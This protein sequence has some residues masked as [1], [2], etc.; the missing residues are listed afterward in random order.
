MLALVASMMPVQVWAYFNRGSVSVALGTTAVEVQA[1]A[2]A[3]VTVAITPSS[4][5][6]TEGCGMPKCPQGCSESCT[7]ENGQCRCAGADYQTYYPSATASSSNASVA[8]ATYSG[9]ALTVYGKQEGEATITVRASLRQFTDAEA[10]LSVKVS[11]AAAGASSGSGAFVDVPEVADTTQED[12]ANV[13]DKVA[14]GRPIHQVRINDACNT[15]VEL[16]TVAGVDGE[17]T[18]WSGDT[19]YHPAYSLTFQGLSY[20]VG[21]LFA[22]DPSLEVLTE[23]SGTLNQMLAGL[24]GFVV[25]DFAHVGA[26]PAPATV[27]VEA[28][29]VLS[30]GQEIAL[31]SYDASAKAFV[32][33]EAP[34][35][36]SGGYATFTVQEGKTYVVS[37]RDLTSEAN[38]VVTGGSSLAQGGK[39]CCDT[40]AGAQGAATQMGQDT[41]P[42]FVYVAAGA[43]A[44]A[45]VAAVVAVL[46]LMRRKKQK[47]EGEED[48]K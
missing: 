23:A 43:G 17:V 32:R 37:S 38:V 21:D 35:S 47:V 6:Q 13:A 11:G 31:F 42:P 12:K 10:T 28:S 2:T 45:V 18:F 29:G 24:D 9:G 14:M 7:D 41:V 46:V 34:A 40:D 1:G 48:R 26:L 25:A 22:F 4:D 27:Y 3:S 5:K 44:V 36:M 33:E 20:T 30:D 8:V 39:S 16:A 15:Q 19:Y